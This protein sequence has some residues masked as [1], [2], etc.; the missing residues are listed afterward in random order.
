MLRLEHEATAAKTLRA[1]KRSPETDMH[2]TMVK[3]R[4][5]PGTKESVNALSAA[6]T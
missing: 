5:N 3:F 1:A 4:E 2:F 6:T